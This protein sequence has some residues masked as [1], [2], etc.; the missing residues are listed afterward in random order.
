MNLP[1]EPTAEQLW[2][3]PIF[4]GPLAANKRTPAAGEVKE[5][6]KAVKAWTKRAKRSDHSTIYRYLDQYPESYWRVSLLT[7]LGRE[8]FQQGYF[9][10]VM[11]PWEKA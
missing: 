11:E 5:L 6:A 9:S 1:D 4:L 10:P 2:D 3:A 8:L 7:N